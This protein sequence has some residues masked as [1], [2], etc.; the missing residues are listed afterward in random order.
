[1]VK[2]VQIL[3]AK[4][5]LEI[6]PGG[7]WI[8]FLSRGSQNPLGP[9]NPR[10]HK[11]HWSKGGWAP[12][13]PLNTHLTPS[14]DTK[15][16]TFD[17][18]IKFLKYIFIFSYK[19]LVFWKKIIFKWNPWTMNILLL[20]KLKLI[21]SIFSMFEKMVEVGIFRKI[22]RFL[23]VPTKWPRVRLQNHENRAWQITKK[24]CRFEEQYLKDDCVNSKCTCT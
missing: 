8:Y 4:A 15:T 13:A 11:S 1:L 10:N 18:T 3:L 12:I 24:N 16:A 7:G 2:K 5:F 22:Y 17:K 20:F 6:C 9:E 23:C 21:T 19:R 14:L